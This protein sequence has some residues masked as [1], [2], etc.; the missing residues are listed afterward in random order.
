MYVQDLERPDWVEET[1]WRAAWSGDPDAAFCVAIGLN[2][3]QR[4]TFALSLTENDCGPAAVR[5]AVEVALT[6]S[7]CF[8]DL[9]LNSL[10]KILEYAAF[11]PPAGTPDRFDIYRGGNAEGLSWS[12]SKAVA[13]QFAGRVKGGTVTARTVRRDEIAFFSN[14]RGEE[15]VIV[16]QD[17]HRD[18]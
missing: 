5:R 1:D 13:Q 11:E 2:D 4:A 17:L 3:Y 18:D 9:G 14:D 16:W 12:L 8:R 7:H 15:E 6:Q 10:R